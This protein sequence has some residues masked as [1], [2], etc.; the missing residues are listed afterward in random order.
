MENKAKPS[1]VGL[2]PFLIFV[3]IY[4]GTGVVLQ[5]KGVGMAFYQLPAPVAVFVGIIAAFILF[6][7]SIIEKFDT[8]LEGCGA[9]GYNYNVY[10]LSACRSFC[11]CI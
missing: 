3:A 7:G 11:R 2:I 5:M 10:N 8:F 4:L 1:F 6:K 9:S